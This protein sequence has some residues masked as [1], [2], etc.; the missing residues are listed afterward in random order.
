MR[1][2][3]APKW[4]QGAALHVGADLSDERNGAA[5]MTSKVARKLAARTGLQ[6]S[7]GAMRGVGVKCGKLC[8]SLPGVRRTTRRG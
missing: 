7:I 1:R 8:I 2:P 4:A 3:G 5:V 6:R